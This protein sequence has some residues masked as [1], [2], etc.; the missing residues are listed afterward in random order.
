M[1]R[2]L[3]CVTASAAILCAGTSTLAPIAHTG[4]FAPGMS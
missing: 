3:A 1:I 4:Q 2:A